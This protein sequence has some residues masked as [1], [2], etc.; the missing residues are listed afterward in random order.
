MGMENIKRQTRAVWLFDRRS[1]F[2]G[3]GLAYTAY[4]L[5]ARTV[6]DTKALLQLRYAACGAI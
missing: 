3:A 5:Y 6:C 4:R 2:V 1:K